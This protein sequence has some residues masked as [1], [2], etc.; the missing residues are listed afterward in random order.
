MTDKTGNKRKAILL[1]NV[2]TPDKPELSSVRKYLSEFLNDPYVIDLPWLLR[3]LL[4]NFII[5]P[6]RSP[7][8]TKLY[9]QLWEK[10]GSP[11]LTNTQ[12]LGNKL[13]LKMGEDY[14][15]FIA[16]RYGNPSIRKAL[17]E[18]ASGKFSEVIVLPLFPQYALSTTETAIQKVYKEAKK[19]NLIPA[20]KVVDQFYNHPEFLKAWLARAQEYDL[21]KYDHFVFSY[22][23]LPLSHIQKSHPQKDLTTCNCTDIMPDFGARCYKATCYATNRLL[24]AQLGLK[25]ADYSLAFQSR[26]TKNWLSPFTDELVIKLAKEGKKHILIFAPAFVADCLETKVELGI[27]YAELFKKA[28]GETLKLVE[29]LNHSDAWVS[30]LDSIIK[31]IN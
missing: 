16:M 17:K 6:F 7:K 1:V 10:E 22:H 25:E 3:K 11:L 20:I 28:G 30:A 27:E 13:A 14:A 26:L 29:S 15:V 21:K 8:S 24:V 9:Q 5:V 18:I 23:G 12:K 4:V 31:E 2:G 19:I